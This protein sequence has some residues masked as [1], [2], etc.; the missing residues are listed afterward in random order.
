MKQIRMVLYKALIGFFLLYGGLSRHVEAKTYTVTSDADSGVGTL[1]DAIDKANKSSESSLINFSFPVQSLPMKIVLKSPLPTITKKVTIDGYANGMGIKNPL[2]IGNGAQLNVVVCRDTSLQELF[3]GFV[4]AAKDCKIQGLCVGD[5][6][7]AFYVQKGGD[8]AEIYGNF[9]GVARSGDADIPNRIGI[10][11]DV[12]DRVT[13]EQNIVSGNTDCGLKLSNGRMHNLIRNLV[14]T[15]RTGQNALPNGTSGIY[16]YTCSQIGLTLSTISGNGATGLYVTDTHTL[17][18]VQC[19]IGT[20]SL[21]NR[22]LANKGHGAEVSLSSDVSFVGSVLSANS[23]S[24]LFLRDASDIFVM[25]CCMGTSK[26]GQKK[27]ANADCG[28][29]MEGCRN[30]VTCFSVL[31]GN[32]SFG[33]YADDCDDAKMRRCCVGTNRGGRKKLANDADGICLHNSADWLISGG[34]RTYLYRNIISGNGGAGLLLQ[35]ADTTDNII[36]YNYIGQLNG[37]NDTLLPNTG[38]TVVY[39]D[40]A[41]AENNTVAHNKLG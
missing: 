7:R 26:G 4:I 20:N 25:G 1:R 18:V 35:G 24:G 29:Y 36:T 27:L 3:D 12:C 23:G 31:S 22:N 41:S 11:I 13:V 15:D 38:G 14:G 2:L 28:I 21:G 33:M 6:D 9:I 5:F 30:I 39:E 40:A 10:R 32:K 19:L 37:R 34:D 17:N 16:M 8:G